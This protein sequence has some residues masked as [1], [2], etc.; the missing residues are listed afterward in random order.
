M[1]KRVCALLCA[2]LLA[3]PLCGMAAAYEDEWTSDAGLALIALR[4]GNAGYLEEGES[5][6][7]SVRREETA[8]QGQAPYA[9]I[10][11]CADARVPPEHIFGG[12]LGD[13]FVVRTAGQVVGRYELGSVEYAAGHLGTPLV[14]VL[15]HSGCGAVAAAMNGHADGALQDIAE[16]I[17]QAIGGE[18]DAAVAEDRNILNSRDRLLESPLLASLVAE[19]QLE[20]VCAKYDLF[21]GG[22]DF[23]T[24]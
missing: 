5:T 11:T 15:G 6:A 4:E 24:E 3:L 18:T 17:A 21:T 8:A 12:G 14:V 22:V 1:K 10:V 19:G 9:I 7:F 23:W 20:I 2:L 13:L 16:E